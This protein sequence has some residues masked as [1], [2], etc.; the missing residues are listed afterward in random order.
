MSNLQILA[1]HLQGRHN[2][3][4]HGRRGGSGGSGETS[5][6]E[7]QQF[8]GRPVKNGK[9]IPNAGKVIQALPDGH[10]IAMGKDR[11]TKVP[12]LVTKKGTIRS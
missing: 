5:S 10:F 3:S 8:V 12:A 9:N 11:G 6:S 2:Q 7:L 4:S 1:K